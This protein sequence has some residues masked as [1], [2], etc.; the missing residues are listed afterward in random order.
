[1]KISYT[2][3]ADC[4]I[5]E[6]RGVTVTGGVFAATSG[7][8]ND[9]IDSVKFDDEIIVA[10]KLRRISAKIAGKPE[11]EQLLAAHNAAEAAKVAIL[12]AIG[13]PQYQAVQSIA[14]NAQGAYESASQHGYPVK[15]AAAMRE[16]DEA[17]D[18]A[19]AQYPL[20]AAYAMAESYSY[21]SHN[22]KASAG[23]KAMAAIQGGA[24]PLQAVAKMESDWSAAA[25]KCCDNA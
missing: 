10:G 24:D 21:A 2:F 16:A 5:A 4:P 11:L 1:M 6:L 12:A 23:R 3:A 25:S 22:Q 20:A 17:L 19:R 9:P 8:Y 14:I 15:Q 7:K 18:A 13:W